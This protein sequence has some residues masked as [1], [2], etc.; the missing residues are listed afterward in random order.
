MTFCRKIVRIENVKH[1]FSRLEF[2]S[3]ES[4]K[5][6]RKE[7]HRKKGYKKNQSPDAPPYILNRRERKTAAAAFKK[8]KKHKLL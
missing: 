3:I 6:N 7:N 1:N 4:E 5:K 2:K 8:P